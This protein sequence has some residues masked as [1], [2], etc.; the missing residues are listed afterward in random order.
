MHD[1]GWGAEGGHGGQVGG[2]EVSEGGEL[3]GWWEGGGG[4]AAVV[5]GVEL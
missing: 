4:E 2:D 1:P 3:S 5:V